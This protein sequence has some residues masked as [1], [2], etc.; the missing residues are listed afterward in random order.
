MS[1]DV[2]DRKIV[3]HNN[4]V[5]FDSEPPIPPSKRRN[6]LLV[7]SEITGIPEN[8]LYLVTPYTFIHNFSMELEFL[9]NRI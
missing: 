6:G 2:N 4:S 9:S 7:V 1:A 8:L 5:E 3:Q